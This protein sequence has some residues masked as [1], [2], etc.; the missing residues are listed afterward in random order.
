MYIILGSGTTGYYAAS[1]LKQMGRQF[2]LVDIKPE[3]IEAL[4]DMGFDNVVKGDI[5]SVGL[6]KKLNIE[7][8]KGVMI[9]TTDLELNLKVAQI[10]REISREVPLILR[11]DKQN[12]SDRYKGLGIDEIIYPA[13][14]VAEKAIESLNE[15]EV[16]RNLKRLTSIID[17]ATG[18]IAIVTQDNPDPDAIASAM[19]LKR[20]IEKM[21]KSAD[22]IYGGEIGYEENKALINLLGIE[23]IPF[24][25]IKDIGKYSKIALVEASIPG[26][27]N[28]LPKELR[29]HII[30]DHHPYDPAKVSADYID[31]RPELGATS[32]IVTEYLTKL[33]FEISEELAT[34]LL[35][36]IKTDTGDFTRGSTP[37][38]LQAVALLYPKAS[39]ELLNKIKTPLMSS[40]TLDVLGEA[41]KN[42]RSIG[43]LL[44]ANVGFIRDRDTLP[45]A[46]DYLLKLEGIST[47]LVYGLSK[48][49]VH[50]SARNKDIRINLSDAMGLAFG[51]IGE[52][53]GHPTAAAAKINL[54]LFGSAKD[55][56]SLLRLAEEAITDRFLKVVGVE[57]KK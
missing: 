55:K 46:A 13:P 51:D 14:A 57:E 16:K 28:S 5:T 40:E 52:A 36:G 49:V 44:M 11:A 37:Q 20:I 45:Q 47:V 23:P 6:L 35:Y 9:L 8:A 22:I 4:R 25:K 34:L 39:Q 18:I 15:L 48:N 42:R 17:E 3:R 26:E 27:N 10:V 24:S 54:G 38:D 32:T 29:P 41:I 56:E 19:T 12:A 53:G 1:H 33:G 50:L 2:T 31:I 21:G 7:Q 30:I 43:S